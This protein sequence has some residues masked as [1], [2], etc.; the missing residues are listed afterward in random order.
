MEKVALVIEEMPR[1]SH[2]FG[3]DR[4]NGG[5]ADNLNIRGADGGFV[6][7][8][9]FADTLQTGGQLKFNSKDEYETKPHENM[10]P[11]YVLTYIIKI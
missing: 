6:N 1:H 9:I 10:P 7:T 3:A 11:F 2:K 8:D 5:N 4:N